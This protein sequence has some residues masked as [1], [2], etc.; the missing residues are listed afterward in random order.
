MSKIPRL[1]PV[2]QSG[3]AFASILILSMGICG[4]PITGS[5]IAQ[6]LKIAPE[7]GAGL[8]LAAGLIPGIAMLFFAAR[9]K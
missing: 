3:L 4:G 9:Q 6:S 7:T 5:L 1:P 8:G 2:E